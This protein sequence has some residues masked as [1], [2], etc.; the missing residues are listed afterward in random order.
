MS[1]GQR[2][3][4]IFGCLLAVISGTWLKDGNSGEILVPN[5]VV[6]VS[7]Y[8]TGEV[9]AIQDLLI[10]QIT[11][12]FP[13]NAILRVWCFADGV[14]P[15]A[16]AIAPRESSTSYDVIVMRLEDL[17][18]IIDDGGG[19]ATRGMRDLLS[20]VEKTRVTRVEFEI[21][22]SCGLLYEEMGES[23]LEIVAERVDRPTDRNNFQFEF[24]VESGEPHRGKITCSLGGGVWHHFYESVIGLLRLRT[25]AENLKA[26]QLTKLEGHCKAVI[27]ADKLPLLEN[28]NASERNLDPSGFPVGWADWDTLTRPE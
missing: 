17:N 26:D 5:H 22:A 16:I 12:H 9:F 20:A 8:T 11:S 28:Y 2:R 18:E 15:I 19:L 25:L 14:V 3:A 23:L 6:P 7:S 10:N 27:G 13:E 1:R 4:K 21:P 24:L